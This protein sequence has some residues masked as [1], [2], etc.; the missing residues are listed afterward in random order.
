MSREVEELD[1][2]SAE[3]DATGGGGAAVASVADAVAAAAR[4]RGG[5][6][7]EEVTKMTKARHASESA[8]KAKM[9]CPACA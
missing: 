4:R 1:G 3:M 2:M 6:A 5:R 9:P 7:C 8:M